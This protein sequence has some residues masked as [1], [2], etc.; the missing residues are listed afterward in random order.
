[1]QSKPAFSQINVKIYKCTINNNLLIFILF[2]T[3][4]M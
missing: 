1:M 2:V 4:E 3:F